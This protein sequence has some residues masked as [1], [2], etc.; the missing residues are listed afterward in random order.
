VARARSLGDAVASPDALAWR[1]PQPP[2]APQ[3]APMNFRFEY[4]FRG[5]DFAGKK[6]P[7]VSIEPC[8]LGSADIAGEKPGD[9]AR[10]FDSDTLIIIAQISALGR[11]NAEQ[12]CPVIGRQAVRVVLNHRDLQPV[13]FNPKF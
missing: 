12:K 6:P 9:L 11:F 4:D 2:P 3:T 5:D 13:G 8:A 10:V 1:S 7:D